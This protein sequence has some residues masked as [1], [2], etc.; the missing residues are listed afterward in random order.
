MN[1]PSRTDNV[2]GRVD[3]NQNPNLHAGTTR[4]DF[5]G[6]ANARVLE[7]LSVQ[8]GIGEPPVPERIE[9]QPNGD[10]AISTIGVEVV[11]SPGSSRRHANTSTPIDPTNILHSSG[12]TGDRYQ[13]G[14]TFN[15][16]RKIRDVFITY[17]KFVGPGFMVSQPLHSGLSLSLSVN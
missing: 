2:D 14:N 12:H 7:R 6:R 11:A 8:D 16:F 10:M 1:C 17:S 9:A 15:I 5:N 3:W 4:E 13:P